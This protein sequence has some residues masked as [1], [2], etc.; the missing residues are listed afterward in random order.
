MAELRVIALRTRY[1]DASQAESLRL[2]LHENAARSYYAGT[3]ECHAT[4]SDVS[5]YAE[6]VYIMSR[7]VEQAGSGGQALLDH[8]IDALRSKLPAETRELEEERFRSIQKSEERE[9][10]E[11]L[12]KYNKEGVDPFA[13]LRA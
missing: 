10:L 2:L 8:W 13:C 7:L 5:R 3:C 1:Q 11:T 4:R 6:I 9:C 12:I